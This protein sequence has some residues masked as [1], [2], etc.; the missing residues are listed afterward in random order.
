MPVPAPYFFSLARLLL[1]RQGRADPFGLV[2][3]DRRAEIRGTVDGATLVVR[4]KGIASN[5]PDMVVAARQPG[6]ADVFERE[7]QILSSH[8]Q[9]ALSG[10]YEG[11]RVFSFL[12]GETVRHVHGLTL[13]D[14]KEHLEAEVGRTGVLDIVAVHE[15]AEFMAGTP[16]GTQV[17]LTKRLEAERAHKVRLAEAR[18][19]ADE[20]YVVTSLKIEPNWTRPVAHP[21]IRATGLADAEAAFREVEPEARITRIEIEPLLD[22]LTAKGAGARTPTPSPAVRARPAA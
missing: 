4:N 11:E 2:Y 14:A 6:Q 17:A 12:V 21:P 7:H 19:S 20:V 8:L 13:S 16:E 5:V 1:E 3:D 15:P 9:H 10:A 22:Y 18:D